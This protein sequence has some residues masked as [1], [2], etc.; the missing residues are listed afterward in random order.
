MRE[1]N[2]W[3]KYKE[4][5]KICEKMKCKQLDLDICRPE[6]IVKLCLPK[7]ELLKKLEIEEEDLASNKIKTTDILRKI[8]E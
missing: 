6:L 3:D 4:V 2:E 1:L 7:K 5:N 8:E